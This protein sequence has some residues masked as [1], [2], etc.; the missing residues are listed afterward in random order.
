[1]YIVKNLKAVN[2]MVR[3]GFELL[4]VRP[5]KFNPN[6]MVF[7]FEDTPEFREKW[8]QYCNANRRNK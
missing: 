2:Y 5:D 6:F 3:C 4:G 1:M 8:T 7:L